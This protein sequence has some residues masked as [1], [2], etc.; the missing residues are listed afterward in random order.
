MIPSHSALRCVLDNLLQSED[1]TLKARAENFRFEERIGKERLKTYEVNYGPSN[2][3]YEAWLESHTNYLSECVYTEIPE[4]FHALNNEAS[5]SVAVDSQLG[6]DQVLIRVESLDYALRDTKIGTLTDL[7]NILAI[8]KCA[9]ND[10]NISV[11]EAK[12][13]LQEVCRSLNQNPFS[14]RPRFAAFAQELADDIDTDEWPTRLRDRLGLAHLPPTGMSG[15]HPVIMM[16]YTVKDVVLRSRKAGA[17]HSLAVPSVLDAEPY[18]IFHP[19]PKNLNYGRT[20][21]LSGVGDGDRLASEVLHMK[22]EYN[23]GHIWK[24]GAITVRADTSPERLATLRSDHLACLQ[25]LSDRDD[26]GKL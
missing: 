4:T 23:P 13:L 26:F 1:Q 17:A 6:E 2:S 12:A 9:R 20:L 14:V 11:S 16:K 8:Y 22:I 7:E 10:S 18:E 15:P 21:D 24:V 5:L 25:L 3:D 19:S